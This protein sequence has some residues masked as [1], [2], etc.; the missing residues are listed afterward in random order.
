M[1]EASIPADLFNPGQA[2]ACLGFLEAADMLLGGAEGGFDWTDETQIRFRLRSAGGE[3]PFAAV[4]TFLAEAVIRPC[5]PRGYADA[6][7]DEKENVAE[8]GDGDG[9]GPAASED[10]SFSESYPNRQA[11]RMAL[12]I[13]LEAGRYRP[14]VLG[15]WADGSS[16][17]DFKLYAG[18]RSAYRIACAML[19][20]TRERPRRNQ[21]NGDIKTR[22]IAAL[23]NEQPEKLTTDPFNVLTLMGGSFNFDAL[24]AWTP[25][26]AGFSPDRQKKAGNIAGISSSPV[27]EFLA[28]WGLEHARPDQYQARQVRYGVWG[29]LLPPVLARPVL[30]GVSAAAPIRRF[31]FTLD[32]SGKN[33]VVTAAQEETNP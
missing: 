17:N 8:D 26:D 21:T 1:A 19:H 7:P 31:R 9:D 18:N 22:G 5:A 25:M 16:R 14:L 13:R 33:K 2:F 11:D 32:L 3:N 12:P 30:A 10:L 24:G 27:V 23:W 6:S 15:H 4:L 20:G 29:G 28:A